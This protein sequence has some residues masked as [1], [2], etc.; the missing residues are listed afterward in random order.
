[1]SHSRPRRRGPGA[2]NVSRRPVR[3]S[4]AVWPDSAVGPGDAGLRAGHATL[5]ARGGGLQRSA[6]GRF[7][8]AS[9]DRH[10]RRPEGNPAAGQLRPVGLVSSW[11]SCPSDLLFSRS[12]PSGIHLAPPEGARSGA[13][14]APAQVLSLQ[15]QTPDLPARSLRQ[16]RP[17]APYLGFAS[18]EGEGPGR[19]RGGAGSRKPGIAGDR[20]WSGWPRACRPE[21]SGSLSSGPPGTSPRPRSG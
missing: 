16:N 10:V 21:P 11:W 1:M 5:Q 7:V 19:P 2:E 13:L 12:Y 18:V 15:W 6:L 14:T 4:S 3:G 8:G 9:T 20:Q 17:V